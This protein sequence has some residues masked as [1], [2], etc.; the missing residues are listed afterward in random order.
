M[1]DTSS[2][3]GSS[4]K[5]GKSAQDLAKELKKLKQ[6]K[7]V[8]KEE[9]LKKTERVTELES[10]GEKNAAKISELEKEVKDKE[11]KVVDLYHQT[12]TQHETISQLQY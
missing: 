8:L 6:Q 3:G 11:T 5:S 1:D 2:K 12:T 4:Q 9:L 7:K 10:L